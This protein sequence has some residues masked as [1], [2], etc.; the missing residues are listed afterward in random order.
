MIHIC[1]EVEVVTRTHNNNNYT[2]MKTVLKTVLVYVHTL[3]FITC[4]MLR[5]SSRL[6]KSNQRALQSQN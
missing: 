1:N 4:T 2:N 3:E 6:V 5:K